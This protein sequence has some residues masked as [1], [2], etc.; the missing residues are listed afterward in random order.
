M[1]VTAAG[2]PQRWYVCPSSMHQC[3][4]RPDHLPGT[5]VQAG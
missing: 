1:M 4:L 5:P 2:T 3:Y